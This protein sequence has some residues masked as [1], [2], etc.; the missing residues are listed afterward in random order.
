MKKIVIGAILGNISAIML[1]S[2]FNIFNF[3]FAKVELPAIQGI[4]GFIAALAGG[5][6][7]GYMSQKRTLSKIMILSI[8]Y[9]LISLIMTSIILYITYQIFFRIDFLATYLRTFLLN[10]FTVMVSGSA[11]ASFQYLKNSE[12]RRLSN[13]VS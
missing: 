4:N 3:F 8:I 1:V 6:L 10:I 13:I 11:G 2:I 12:E 7:A 5:F 9:S